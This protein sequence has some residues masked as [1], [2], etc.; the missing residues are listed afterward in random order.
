MST[1]K[2]FLFINK[3]LLIIYSMLVIAVVILTRVLNYSN[4]H[5]FD[6]FFAGLNPVITCF[7]ITILGILCL[8]YLLNKSWFKIYKK[9]DTLKLLRTLGLAV[10]FVSITILID[11]KIHFPI[12]MNIAFPESLLFYPLIGFLAEILFH[13]LPMTVLLFCLSSIFENT[14]IQK[15]IW[16]SIVVIA[17]LEPI[18][19]VSAMA[20]YPIWAI[21]L[22]WI[23]LYLF[24]LTQ[25]IIF[26][27]FDFTAMYLFRLI[28]YLFWHVLWGYARLRGI[29]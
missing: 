16:F 25:L 21:I 14:D 26:K 19:Q 11:I 28:Y 17:T 10:L 5:V 8:S 20:A 4:R 24:N 3:K 1:L 27:Q 13:V 9:N 2:T 15:I 22:V 29:F 18:Y 7:V 12:D 23:N 6:R